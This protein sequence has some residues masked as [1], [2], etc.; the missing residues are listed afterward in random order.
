MDLNPKSTLKMTYLFIKS[1]LN[2]RITLCRPGAKLV[3]SNIVNFDANN[4]A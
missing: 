2:M 4:Y 1:K 3:T